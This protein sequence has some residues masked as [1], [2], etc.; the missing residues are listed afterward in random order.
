MKHELILIRHAKSSWDDASLSDKKRPLNSRGKEDA[1]GMANYISNQVETVD[2]LLCST[3]KRTRQ[4][5]DYFI[6]Q[7][8]LQESQ[9]MY[10][11]ELYHA[12]PSTITQI[13]RSVNENVRKLALI[14]HNPGFTDVINMIPHVHLDNLPTCGIYRGE[15]KG[16]WKIFQFKELGHMAIVYP[17]ILPDAS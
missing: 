7:W 2:L 1:P 12:A 5:A 10:I 6:E 8:K 9:V 16:D 3:A 13:I 14:G 11:D 4:T 15:F 17:K